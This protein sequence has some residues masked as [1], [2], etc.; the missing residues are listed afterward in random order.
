M[1]TSASVRLSLQ[2]VHRHYRRRR[3]CYSAACLLCHVSL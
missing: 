1:L 3:C 2:H